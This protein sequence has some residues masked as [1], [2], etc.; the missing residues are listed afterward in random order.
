[1]NIILLMNKYW[2]LYYYWINIEYI[3]ILNKYW[4][5]LLNI[6]YYIINE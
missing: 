4:I 1:M 6:E 2:I 5:L 3:I